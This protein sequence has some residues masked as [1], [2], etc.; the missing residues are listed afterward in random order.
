MNALLVLGLLGASAWVYPDL[1]ARIPLHF[2]PD[3]QPDRWGDTTFLSWMLLPLIGAA[4][5]LLMYA[6]TWF[7]RT[8][9]KYINMPDK[10]KFMQLPTHLQQWVAGGVIGMVN[11]ITLAVLAMFCAIQY[12]AWESAHSGNGSSVMPAALVLGLVG[13]PFLTIAIFVVTQHRMDT[14]W[15]QWQA[16]TPGG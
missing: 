14:A 6:C 3:G 7:V 9:P 5:A 12:G 2:G 8:R 16:E 10:K 15:K 11:I 4:T 13:M 1:P